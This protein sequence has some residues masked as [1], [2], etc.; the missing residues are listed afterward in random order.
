MC[1]N[2]IHRDIDGECAIMKF[3]SD[4]FADGGITLLGWDGFQDVVLYLSEKHLQPAALIEVRRFMEWS[5]RTVRIKAWRYK[6]MRDHQRKRTNNGSGK[7]ENGFD[8]DGRPRVDL[9]VAQPDE[10]EWKRDG[11]SRGRLIG[12]IR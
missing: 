4:V 11:K 8:K 10:Q 3:M 12:K 1:F 6:V 2:V 5:F 7:F 9:E